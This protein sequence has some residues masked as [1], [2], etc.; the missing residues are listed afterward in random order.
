MVTVQGIRSGPMLNVISAMQ[1]RSFL[2]KGCEGFLALALDSKGGQVNLENIPV[3][4]EF[5]YMF[6]EELLG[7]PPEIEVDMSIEVV[8]G[9]TPISRAP[10]HM[11]PTKLK[12]LKT[13]LQELLDKGFGRLSVSP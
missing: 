11:A 1:A 5:L 7:F 3:I 12:E 10:Y 13:Q 2:M 8:Q 9:T 6:P 4:K